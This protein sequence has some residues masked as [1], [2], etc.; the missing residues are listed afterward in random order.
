MANPSFEP[1]THQCLPGA[2][3][4]CREV[5]CQSFAF[6]ASK[7][8]FGPKRP[9]TQQERRETVP[10][11]HMCHFC[12]VTNSPCLPPKVHSTSVEEPKNGENWPTNERTSCPTVP[13]RRT[14][15]ILDWVASKLVRTAPS[16]PATPHF[17]WF[18][19]LGTTQR[20][21]QTPIPMVTPCMKRVARAQNGW[22]PTW[23]GKFPRAKNIYF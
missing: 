12:P 4:P 14:G 18:A 23:S 1:Q 17:L 3:A 7:S 9:Q 10:T 11:L 19:T 13:Q 8:F 20:D 22:G 5:P 15:H 6:S 21:A 2:G 16:P